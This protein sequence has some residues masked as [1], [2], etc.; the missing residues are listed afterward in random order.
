MNHTVHFRLLNVNNFIDKTLFGSYLSFLQHRS[1]NN[2]SLVKR[3]LNLKSLGEKYQALRD[4]G[5]GP[6]TKTLVKNMMY[7]VLKLSTIEITSALNAL[8]NLSF[9]QVGNDMLELLQRFESLNVHDSARKQSSISTY[10]N[11]K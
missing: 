7:L 4:P 3:K 6:Q 8:H 5:K 2:L 10:S 9:S 11:Q 1:G